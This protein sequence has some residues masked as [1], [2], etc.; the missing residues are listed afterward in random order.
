MLVEPVAAL[1]LGVASTNPAKVAAVRRIMRRLNVPYRLRAEAVS[2]GVPEQPR[3][4]E[5]TMRGAVQR[6][7]AMLEATDVDVAVAFEGGVDRTLFGT[8]ACEWCAVRDRNGT[9]GIGGGAK[10]LLPEALAERVLRGESLATATSRWA[11]EVSQSDGVFGLLTQGA[12]TRE[13]VNGDILLLA[14]A[15]FLNAPVYADPPST[16]ASMLGVRLAEQLMRRRPA[17]AHGEQLSLRLQ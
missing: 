10:I 7:E 6:T 11:H 1:R 15:R 16:F 3:T 14:L 17:P 8:F 4:D 12:L 13:R 9:V 5:D 2:S